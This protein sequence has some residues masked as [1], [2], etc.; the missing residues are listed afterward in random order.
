MGTTEDHLNR[1]RPLGL[2]R[3]SSYRITIR[4][5]SNE[6][7]LRFREPF[8]RSPSP[9]VARCSTGGLFPVR[10][11]STLRDGGALRNHLL[12][13]ITASLH[14]RGTKLV[15]PGGNPPRLRRAGRAHH[16]ACLPLKLVVESARVGSI[17]LPAFESRVGGLRHRRQTD[18]PSGA[19]ASLEP[20]EGIERP[21]AQS[22]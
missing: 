15:L 1:G 13:K 16:G 14:S 6:S 17:P 8:V 3:H 21:S 4:C 12:R 7:T 2:S 11:V 19:A 18:R 22:S 10:A 20:R 5:A 9:G